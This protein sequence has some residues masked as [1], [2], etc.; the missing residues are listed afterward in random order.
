MGPQTQGMQG[1]AGPQ[2]LFMHLIASSPTSWSPL[3]PVILLLRSETCPHPAKY[4][5]H[6]WFAGV[7]EARKT[8]P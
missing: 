6:L 5:I 1:F 3:K 2:P 4:L 7:M 8:T